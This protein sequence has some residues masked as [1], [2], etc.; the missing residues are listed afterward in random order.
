MLWRRKTPGPFAHLNVENSAG[1]DKNMNE[2]RLVDTQP[3]PLAKYKAKK[4]LLSTRSALNKAKKALL[5]KKA[6][7][8][9]HSR[10]AR[11]DYLA[12]EAQALQS[13][14]DEDTFHMDDGEA[15]SAEEDSDGE[16][17]EVD[18]GDEDDAFSTGSGEAVYGT[19]FG[20]FDL[21]DSDLFDLFGNDDSDF[22]S[23]LAG[24]Q[25]NAEHPDAPSPMAGH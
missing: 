21:G 14:A 17:V 10:G 9:S 13:A 25:R 23:F 6:V 20:D 3:D 1:L 5:S 22:N 15:D 8:L 16:D 12:L 18:E 24:V 2:M 7:L 11:E 4:A 19:E